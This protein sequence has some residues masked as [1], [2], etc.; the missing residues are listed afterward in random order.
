MIC[1][2]GQAFDKARFS[3]FAYTTDCW[4]PNYE[5]YLVEVSF[6]QLYPSG[7][8]RVGVWGNDDIGMVRDFENR[9]LAEYCYA[10]VIN[11][12]YVTKDNLS[13]KG[14]EYF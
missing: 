6:Q 12:P 1:A 10:A 3:T 7:L 13:I 14:F 11:E 4:S 8:W 5:R 9:A 2:N